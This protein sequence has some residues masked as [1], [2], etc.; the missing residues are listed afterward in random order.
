[1]NNKKILVLSYSPL[2]RDPRVRR[3]IFALQGEY[4]ITAAGLTNPEID[5]VEFIRIGAEEK[6]KGLLPRWITV[7]IEIWMRRFGFY[8][9]FYW[10]SGRLYDYLKLLRKK[11]DL[12]I[13]N[14]DRALPMA[15][16]LPGKHKILAD[17]HEY[18]LDYYVKENKEKR[19]SLQQAETSWRCLRYLPKA[20]AVTT[21]CEGLAQKYKK[22]VCQ[23]DISVIKNVAPFYDLEPTPIGEKIRIIHHGSGAF[24]RNIHNLILVMDRVDE[25]YELDLMLLA[26]K[27]SEYYR[28][29]EDMA[30]MRENVK[31]IP[32]VAT[33]DIVSF[34]HNYDIGLYLLKPVNFNQEQALPNKL[35]EFIQAR[36]AVIIGPSVEMA[37]VV[38]KYQCGRIAED[39]NPI[40]CASLLNS[41][42]NEDIVEM[43]KQA[44]VAAKQENFEQ[45]GKKLTALIES[46]LH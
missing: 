37:S 2:H 21:V 22:E 6:I 45:D 19:E 11:Y 33:E 8:N 36:L 34:T 23:R 1:M 20:D 43:K 4:E 32:P 10:K 46:T 13:A 17:M 39:F 3:Q 5:G 9:Y 41:L 16:S 42:T 31:L 29:L 14:D 27:S 24:A 38:N 44:G 26:D 12:I 18:F 15:F 25:R 35:F 28:I 7:H 30:A 40:T